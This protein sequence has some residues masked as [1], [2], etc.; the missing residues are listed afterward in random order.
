ML[1]GIFGESCTGKTTAAEKLGKL[2]NAEVFTGKDYL[3]LAKNEIIA[4]KQFCKRLEVA[5]SGENMVYVIAE[6]EHLKLLPAGAVRILMTAD[7]PVIEERF[8]KRMHGTLPP[9]VKTMLEK[10]H[11]I[12]DQEDHNYHIHNGENLDVVC[13]SIAEKVI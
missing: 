12:F 5:V 6:R 13:A 11:G 9:P 4:Q 7:L 2:L 3:R 8:A 1:I 10:K